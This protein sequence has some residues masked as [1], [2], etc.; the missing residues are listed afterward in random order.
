MAWVTIATWDFS[1]PGVS[2]AADLLARGAGAAD[3]AQLIAEYAENDP[4]VRFVGLGGSPNICGEM[5]LDAA[6]MD[7][8][9]LAI[10][11]VAALKGFRNP[12]A[13]ARRLMEKS[14]FSFL[15]GAGAED[16]AAAEGFEREIMLSEAS[17]AL[18]RQRMQQLRQGIPLANVVGHDTIGI[19]TMDQAGH[20][21]AASSTSGCELKPRGRVGDSP[22]VGSGYYVDS[23]VGGAAATGVGEDIMKGCASFLAVQLMQQGLS[24]RDAAEE[25]VRRCHRRLQEH[26]S[27]VGNIALV[28]ADRLGRFG[29]AANHPGFVY[30]AAAEN[31]PVSRCEVEPVS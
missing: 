30:I 7:G 14:F 1:L 15:V 8:D 26:Q 12:I 19:I 21:A 4:A 11:A 20:M 27:T 2:A 24:P 22:L 28:C 23:T 9:S 29:G 6:F 5:E 17:V 10:G 25:A 18:W 3:A 31:R 13:V 16:F